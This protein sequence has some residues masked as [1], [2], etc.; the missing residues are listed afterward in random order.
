MSACKRCASHRVALR[1]VHGADVRAVAVEDR[2]VLMKRFLLNLW[3]FWYFLTKKRM[4]IPMGLT[5]AQLATLQADMAALTAAVATD[6]TNQA[7]VDAATAQI[8]AD[9]AAL[10]TAQTAATASAAAVTAAG[11]QLVSDVDNDFPP[12]PT[13]A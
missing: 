4:V 7:A 5:P 2:D 10:T 13:P 6:T 9:Q 3:F 12:T 8:A 1:L 11:N